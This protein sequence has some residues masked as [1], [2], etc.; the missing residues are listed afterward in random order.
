V[1]K[2]ASPFSNRSST[3]QN[4]NRAR[5]RNILKVNPQVSHFSQNLFK[6]D[7]EKH[8]YDEVEHR[9]IPQPPVLQIEPA[10]QPVNELAGGKDQCK[11]EFLN[12][13]QQWLFKCEQHAKAQQFIELSSCAC[14]LAFMALVVKENTLAM[15]VYSICAEILLHEH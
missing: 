14:V 10:W 5:L 8:R 13:L 7:R 3:A 2:Q 6:S 11:V 1:S 9:P 4:V 15:K 12:Q